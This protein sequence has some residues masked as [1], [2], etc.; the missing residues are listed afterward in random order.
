MKRIDPRT[1]E[2]ESEEEVA[3]SQLHDDLLDM[4]WNTLD[5]AVHVA[6]QT[7]VSNDVIEYLSEGY[8]SRG[9]GDTIVRRPIVTLDEV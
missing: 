1:V 4:G 2:F 5:A 9:L 6:E 8:V 7:D 3:A